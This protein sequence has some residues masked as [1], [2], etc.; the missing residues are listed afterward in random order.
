MQRVEGLRLV[1]S[2]LRDVALTKR[3]HPQVNERVSKIF[4]AQAAYA[5][6]RH[7]FPRLAVY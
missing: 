2:L 3:R 7:D 5:L 1:K 4:A 6:Q